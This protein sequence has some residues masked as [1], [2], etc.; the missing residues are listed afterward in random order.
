MIAGNR[1]HDESLFAENNNT[2]LIL[3]SDP[4]K[5]L[6]LLLK[7]IKTGFVF[8]TYLYILYR[9]AEGHVN[10]KHDVIILLLYRNCIRQIDRA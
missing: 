10:G 4:Y 7:H 2:E 6:E 9:H 8:L 3:V 1:R 5:F